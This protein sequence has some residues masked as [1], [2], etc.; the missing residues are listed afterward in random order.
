MNLYAFAHGDPITFSE[1]LGLEECKDRSGKSFLNRH[2][3]QRKRINRER[4]AVDPVAIAADIA[5][6]GLAGATKAIGETVVQRLTRSGWQ[7]TSKYRAAV[8]QLA[9]GGAH[10]AVGGIVPTIDEATALIQRGGDQSCE[11]KNTR[12]VVSERIPIPTSITPPSP[13]QRLQ[14]ECNPSIRDLFRG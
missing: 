1:P 6:G 14:S 2:A 11:L 13:E 3:T 4:P 5:A 10:E 7:G 8:R 9:S 12:L